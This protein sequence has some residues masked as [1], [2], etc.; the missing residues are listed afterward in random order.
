MTIMQ[1][2]AQIQKEEHQERKRRGLE[3]YIN[4]RQISGRHDGL[5]SHIENF[6]NAKSKQNR[7]L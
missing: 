5:I 3:N 6:G 4:I 7:K 2:D 1:E